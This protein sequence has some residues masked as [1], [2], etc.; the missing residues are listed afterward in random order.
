ML[1]P[2]AGTTI[3][4]AKQAMAVRPLELPSRMVSCDAQ[5]P[6]LPVTQGKVA[7]HPSGLMH[8]VSGTC[9]FTEACFH[10]LRSGCMQ[11]L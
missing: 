5:A 11:V 3:V 8:T 7:W 9:A 2:F 1:S 4:M 10:L 6:A